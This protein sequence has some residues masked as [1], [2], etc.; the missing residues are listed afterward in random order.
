[1]V[2]NSNRMKEAVVE[3]DADGMQGGESGT[4]HSGLSKGQYDKWYGVGQSV[5]AAK[6]KSY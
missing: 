5:E 4:A 6:G 1:M 2:G 3:S